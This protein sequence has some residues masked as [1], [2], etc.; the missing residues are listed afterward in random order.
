MDGGLGLTAINGDQEIL[1]Q[2][3][4]NIRILDSTL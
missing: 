4:D 3:L 1:L 2:Q